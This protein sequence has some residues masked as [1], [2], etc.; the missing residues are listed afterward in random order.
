MNRIEDLCARKHGAYNEWHFKY[1]NF[2]TMFE[3]YKRLRKSGVLK[4]DT[5]EL[6]EYRNKLDKTL[7]EVESAKKEY[8][9]L[10]HDWAML[11]VGENRN[12]LLN[13]FEGVM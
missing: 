9:S 6:F 3:E 5:K 8:D 12:L 11:V 10:K 4:D 1:N 7:E 13:A 2:K